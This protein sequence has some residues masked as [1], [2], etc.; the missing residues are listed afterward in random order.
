M[1]PYFSGKIKLGFRQIFFGGPDRNP[2]AEDAKLKKQPVEYYKMLYADTALGEAAP[3]RC[4]HDFFGTAKCLFAT[5]A[6][7][8]AEQG[9]ALIRKTIAA[10]NA[11]EIP[12][13]EKDAIFEGNAKKLLRL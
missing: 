11:L 4:G 2:A 12:A 9:R 7:F 10:V 1:I 8:D 13:A 5:D 6:P 3:T